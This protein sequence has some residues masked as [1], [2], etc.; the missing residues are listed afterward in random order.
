M[1]NN[2]TKRLLLGA[3]MGMSLLGSA[4][5]VTFDS[6]T[7]GRAL[8]GW[9]KNRTASYSIDNH[10]YRT[11]RPTLTRNPGGGLFISARVE[12][13]RSFGKKTTSYIELSYSAEGTLVTAQI[14]I[15]AGDF[16]VNSGLINRPALA[17]PAEGE[18]PAADTEPW[19][20]PTGV[21]IQDLFKALDNEVAK[22]AKAGDGKKDIFSR[23]FG[24][25]YD[26]ADLAAALRHNLNL[27]M[28]CVR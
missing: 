6:D 11:H 19:N 1:N 16:R 2:I 12:H 22:M 15:M 13:L 5:A 26:S 28:A 27:L 3:F 14:R 17:A 18:A 8:N 23:A 7:F 24:R 10:S 21:M 20:N 4:S 9:Q 25:G